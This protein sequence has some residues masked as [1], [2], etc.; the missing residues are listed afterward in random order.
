MANRKLS[1]TGDGT[2]TACVVYYVADTDAGKPTTGL[3]IGDLCFAVDTKKFYK[4]TST[5]IW[6]DCVAY[7]L[8]DSSTTVK[9]ILKLATAPASPTNPIA[10]GDNDARMSDSRAPNGNATG[11]LGGTYPSPSVNRIRG[12][13]V[14]A[15]PPTANQFLKY[16][17]T[18][19]TPT[20]ETTYAPTNVSYVVISSDGTLTNEVLFASL[21]LQNRVASN[22]TTTLTTAANV[23]N[24]VFAIPVSEN[25]SFEFNISNGCNNIGGLKWA[26]TVPT[27]AT[28]RAV[29]VGMSTVATAA[30]SAIMTVSGTLT[31]AFNAANLATGWTRITGTCANSTNT[32]NVQLQFAST[33][34]GQTSTVFANSYFKAR[35]I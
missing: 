33:T 12:T 21:R 34:S 32:G 28:F 19:W 26:I 23:T 30:T 16:V 4:A 15:T 9:G 35:K 10:V 6:S 31:I 14:S 27:G 2:D 11:D 13:D 29:A 17:G 5:T 3:V 7:E 18:A 24:M 20:A 1:F 8:Q 25:W 22:Q